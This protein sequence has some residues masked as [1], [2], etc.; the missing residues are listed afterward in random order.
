MSADRLKNLQKNFA[1]MFWIRAFLHLKIINAVASLF[2]IHRG[3]T[4]AEVVYV[5][6]FWAIGNFLFEIPSSYLADKWGRKK[7]IILG[8]ILMSLSWAVL[9]FATGFFWIAFSLFLNGVSYACFSGTDTALIYDTKRELSG[10]GDSLRELGRYSSAFSIFKIFT[11]IIGAYLARNLLPWQF[12]L[13][14]LI[15]FTG[16]LV[17][18]V[19][20]FRLIEARHRM[21]VEKQEAGVMLDAIKLFKKYPVLLRAMLNEE[22][23]FYACF[24]TWVYFQKFYFDLGLTVIVIGL[25]WSLHSLLNFLSHRYSEKIFPRINLTK[26]IDKLNMMSVVLA[27]LVLAVWFLKLPA[28]VMYIVYALQCTAQTARWPMF[29]EF[30][31]KH[32]LSFNRATTLSL[33]NLLHNIIEIPMLILAGILVSMNT[34]YPYILALLIGLFVTILVRLPKFT[35]VET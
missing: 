4:L 23:M 6:I 35:L 24:I 13:L 15:D 8:V 30:F 2:Y 32:S 31:N 28:I 14:I 26:R 7:T 17:A 33:A 22:L 20:S 1:R 21:D 16:T 11:V 34:I 25:V 19:F 3:L 12:N 18:L 27:F 9:L 29:D 10:E 5:G